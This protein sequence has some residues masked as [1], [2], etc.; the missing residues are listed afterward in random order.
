[1]TSTNRWL[2]R[3]WTS[4]RLALAAIVLALL[5]GGTTVFG[6]T[7]FGPLTT[8]SA[9]NIEPCFEGA[10]MRTAPAGSGPSPVGRCTP[11]TSQTLLDNFVWAWLVGC[12]A[13]AVVVG[14]RVVRHS[15]LLDAPTDPS[16]TDVAGRPGSVP[17]HD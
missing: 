17:P 11:P 10:P 3:W 2:R 14:I 12:G 13:I 9:Q 5:I 8:A 6:A 7:V 4:V 15:P 1:V 16:P